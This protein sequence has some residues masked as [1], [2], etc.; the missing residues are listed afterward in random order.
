MPRSGAPSAPGAPTRPDG[1]RVLPSRVGGTPAG[2]GGDWTKVYKE[3]QLATNA[4]L[5]PIDLDVSKACCWRIDQ[6]DGAGKVAQRGTISNFTTE[7]GNADRP[8]PDDGGIFVEGGKHVLRWRPGKH[9]VRQNIY[10]GESAD[11]VA[12][13]ARPLQADLA[14][15]VDS[16]PLP[17]LSPVL[18]KT[19]SWR[20]ESING[21]RLS[22]SAGDLWGFRTVGKKLRVYLSLG[23]SNAVGCCSVNGIPSELKGF[24]RNVII[25]VRGEC[26]L[27][28]YG[29][30][31]L[32]D[33]LGSAFGDYD[34]RGTFGPELS[35]GHGMAP[36]TPETVIAII[37]CAWGGTNLGVQWRPPSAGGE[38]GPLYKGFIEA[39]HQGIAKLDP[40]FEPE[41]AGMIW[42]QGE[43]DSGDPKMADDYAGNLA[44]LIRD[45][46][47]E[48]KTPDLPFVVA[49]ISKAPAWEPRGET[50]RAAARSVSKTVPG[51]AT[52]ATDDYG[53]CD[54]WHYDTPGMVSLGE[55]FAKAMQGLEKDKPRR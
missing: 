26:R 11:A 7:T 38:T 52:F 4:R 37:K 8:T 47:A 24:D 16:L 12:P 45:I 28:E 1:A 32:R 31:Y 17:V 39:V 9:A 29:W 10:F 43:S 5:G 41:F 48:L 14:S 23:Q 21:G 6:I 25:F 2:D 35:F 46:R 33:G 30:A 34:G 44:C 15:T 50:I 36:R 54:P 42:M 49:Q 40:A 55:R 19:Y 18:G 13:G 20:V 22:V 3:R 53:M 51:T 27:G